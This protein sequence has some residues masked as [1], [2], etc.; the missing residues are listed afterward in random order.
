M[1]DDSAVNSDEGT[2]YLKGG[3]LGES[4]LN[5]TPDSCKDCTVTCEHQWSSSQMD[6]IAME[7]DDGVFLKDPVRRAKR[8]AGNYAQLFLDDE[9]TDKA[10]RFYWPGLAAFAAKE[11]V[12]GMELAVQFLSWDKVQSA[13][14]MAR[15]SAMVTFYYLAKGNLWVFLEVTTWHLFYKKYGKE[16]FEHCKSRRDVD[17]YDDV[18]KPIVKGLPWAL[19]Q[20]NA[21]IDALRKRANP[22]IVIGPDLIRDG[23][24]LSEMKNCKVTTFLSNGFYLLELYET[25]T[26][27]AAKQ[28]LAYEAAWQFLLH[29]QTLH[30]QVMVY[31]HPEFQSAI[32]MNDFGRKP[33]IR[34]F[35]GAK[36]PAVFFNAS[37]EITPD[38][39]QQQLDHYD[40]TEDDIKV[41]M[42]DGKLYKTDDRMIYVKKIL[43]KYH[44]LMTNA[45]YRPYMITQISTISGWKNA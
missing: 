39:A 15:G 1:A 20:N 23:A 2:V 11:V 40:L 8:T 27:D 31:N 45:K 35:S 38:I 21:L 10:G 7:A 29:E 4:E 41:E 22:M 34:A 12:A 33:V 16:L 44:Y 13:L 32:D 26:D 5:Q 9:G 30:L 43:K 17:T 19:G 14:A 42:G 3:L 18:V 6:N 24:A 36:D 25:S 28:N 37:A